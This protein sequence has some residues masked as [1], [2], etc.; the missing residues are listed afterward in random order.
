VHLRSREMC[1]VGDDERALVWYER[2]L[3]SA[4]SFVP[5]ATEA[6]WELAEHRSVFIGERPEHAGHAMHTN[7]SS[8][9]PRGRLA[10]DFCTP[11]I[12]THCANDRDL[13]NSAVPYVRGSV[14]GPGEDRAARS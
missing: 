6:V 3:G 5:S 13:L 1:G 2:L 11:A 4:P 12:R 7:F 8:K 10:C 14:A 9:A